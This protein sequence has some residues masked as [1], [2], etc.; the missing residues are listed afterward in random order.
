[1]F[2]SILW[3]LWSLWGLCNL[4]GLCSKDKN[5]HIG[6]SQICPGKY[7]NVVC[8]CKYSTFCIC[9]TYNISFNHD[10]FMQKP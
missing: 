8:G 9:K 5:I 6:I 1:M 4:C 3:G 10:I 2:V 7:S